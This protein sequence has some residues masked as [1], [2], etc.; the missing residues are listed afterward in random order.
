MSDDYQTP[1]KEGVRPD[2][3]FDVLAIDLVWSEALGQPRYVG[4]TAALNP[5]WADAFEV[6]FYRLERE[7][8]SQSNPGAGQDGDL[9]LPLA[10]AATRAGAKSVQ[11]STVHARLFARPVDWSGRL[12]VEV[13]L[14]RNYRW[15]AVF[16]APE[17]TWV[18]SN[19]RRKPTMGV[20]NISATPTPP[21][22]GSIR[23]EAVAE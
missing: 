9:T 13:A 1:Q 5:S 20:I 18:F 14:R 8:P 6:R 23:F 16:H 2:V 15:S 7:N 22:R 12:A 3:D 4:T 21:N 10:T 19:W 11:N 17:E